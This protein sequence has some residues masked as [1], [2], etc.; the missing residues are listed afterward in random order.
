M[1]SVQNTNEESLGQQLK[2]VRSQ[3]SIRQKQFASWVGLGQSTISGLENKV[4]HALSENKRAL[5][6]T[7]IRLL[8]QDPSA[9][10]RI[11]RQSLLRK[12]HSDLTEGR[13]MSNTVEVMCPRCER[14]VPGPA[15][16]A[17]LCFVCGEE[18]GTFC[19]CGYH[20]EDSRHW[21]CPCC[22]KPIPEDKITDEHM[23]KGESKTEQVRRR[24]IYEHAKGLETGDALKRLTN[25]LDPI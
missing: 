3:H 20:F 4:D 25:P 1:T 9:I 10:S 8:E 5:I 18:L 12:A 17:R 7:A 24:L 13:P 16:G 22:G 11:D 14:N 23:G 6:R 19:P 15:S 2:R 21:I